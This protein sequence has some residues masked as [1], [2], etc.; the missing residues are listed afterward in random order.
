MRIR[1]ASMG[2]VA[3]LERCV[4]EAYRGYVSRIG[5]SPAS[6]ERDFRPEIE[7]GNVHVC[8]SSGQLLAIM[9]VAEKR[10]H[11][12]VSSLAVRPS[13]QRQGIGRRLMGVAEDLAISHGL[14]T[15]KLYTNAAL[16]EV[17][18]YY[19]HLGY[20]QFDRRVEEGYDRVFLKKHVRAAT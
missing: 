18:R 13:C 19:E 6:M 2:D 8:E 7:E 11:L 5:R 9:V 3:A 17:I 12:E 10:D 4:A 15:V 14:S 20:A 16:P 1:L